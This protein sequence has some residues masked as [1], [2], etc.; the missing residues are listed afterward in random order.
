MIFP[1]LVKWTLEVMDGVLVSILEPEDKS[2]FLG[3]LE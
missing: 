3:K 1:H 2:Y